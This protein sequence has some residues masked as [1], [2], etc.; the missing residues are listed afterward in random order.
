MKVSETWIVGIATGGYIGRAPFA[1]GTLGSLPGVL[2]YFFMSGKPLWQAFL[3][4]ALLIL[5][6]VWVAG[7]AE[8]LL[9]THDPGCIVIDEIAGMAVTFFAIPFHVPLMIIGFILFRFFDILK[10]F[11]IGVAD[12]RLTGGVGVVADDVVAGIFSNIVLQMLVIVFYAAPAS[13]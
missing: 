8:K 4:L 6:A 7:R 9:N 1:P 12:R 10:P 13:A 11:L 3:V 5:S 2:Y